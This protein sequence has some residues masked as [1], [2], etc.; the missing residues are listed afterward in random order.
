MIDHEQISA[1]P[2]IGRQCLLTSDERL[3]GDGGN[4]PLNGAHE[5]GRHRPLILDNHDLVGGRHRRSP[6]ERSIH[7]TALPSGQ[8]G[9]GSRS[10][11][12]EQAA[13]HQ[14]PIAHTPAWRPS[15]RSTTTAGQSYIRPIFT[16]RWAVL[17]YC[18]WDAFHS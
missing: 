8:G 17:Y 16:V 18:Q 12:I 7:A 9:N 10:Y 2:I 6:E 4:L 5:H 14:R 1:D 13:R 3:D 15:A 11:Y